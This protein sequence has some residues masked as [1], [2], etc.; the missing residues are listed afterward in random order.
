MLSCLAD[1]PQVEPQIVNGTYLKA[2]DFLGA[3]QVVKIG[4]GIDA[5]GLGRGSRVDG[6][7][8]GLPFLVLQFSLVIIIHR[9]YL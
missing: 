3:D 9:G 2:K 1:E 5:V 7:E 6:V 4:E 8:A